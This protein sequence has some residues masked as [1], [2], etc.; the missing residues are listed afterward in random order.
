MLFRSK[1]LICR[2]VE[3][4]VWPW[5]HAGIVKP[6]IDRVLPLSEAAAAHT[7]LADGVATGKVLLTA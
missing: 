7:L 4:N 6:V 3:R 2:Q 5:I 1:A